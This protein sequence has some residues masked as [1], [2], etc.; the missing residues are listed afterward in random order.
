MNT[1]ISLDY[2]GSTF[3]TALSEN[4]EIEND[5][6]EKARNVSVEFNP[7][8][9]F[10]LGERFHYIDAALLLEYG[11]TRFNNTYE[12]WVGGGTQETYWNTNIVWGDEVFWERFSYANENYFDVGVDISAMFPL[13]NKETGFLGFGFMLLFD[14][15]FTFENKYYGTNSDNG[16]E[17][18]FTVDRRREN[19]TREIW[20]NSAL[21]LQIVKQPFHI[22]FEV[23]EPFLYSLL[24]RTRITD[25]D[26]ETVL[27]EH[28]KQPLWLSQKGFGIGLFL[29]YEMAGPFS[30]R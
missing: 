21:M 9:N 5:A 18:T 16:T 3:G 12:R 23:I 1:F 28:E 24:P 13:I 19:F 17:I 29:A 11:Y 26:D 7:N 10:I 8:I 4:L 15:K 22:R 25:K 20:F 27:Y 6:K 30:R 14:T 2:E